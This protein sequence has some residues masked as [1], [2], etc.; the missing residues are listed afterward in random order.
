MRWKRGGISFTQ[1]PTLA[2]CWLGK[3]AVPWD[4]PGWHE[5]EARIELSDSEFKSEPVGIGWG[6]RQASGK[7]QHF[8]WVLTGESASHGQYVKHPKR[9]GERER[10]T[11]GP[12]L[13]ASPNVLCFQMIHAGLQIGEVITITRATCCVP[14][15]SQTLC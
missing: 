12:V 6:P 7:R 2:R 1:V 15:C 4:F 3:D 11:P 14:P 9:A 5:Q 8:A 13:Q 10:E